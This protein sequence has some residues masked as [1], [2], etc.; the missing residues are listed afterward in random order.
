MQLE[1]H[2]QA[3]LLLWYECRTQENGRRVH[4]YS[5]D[6]IAEFLK[7]NRTSQRC[8]N[9][10]WILPRK[11]QMLLLESLQ[12]DKDVKELETYIFLI[13]NNTMI[14]NLASV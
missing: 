7:L 10:Q 12:G 14:L 4:G 9:T 1:P 8:M 13:N 3:G 6:N 2:F 5:E 11:S